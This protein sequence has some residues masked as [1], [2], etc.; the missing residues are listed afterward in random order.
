MKELKEMSVEQLE[1]ELAARKAEET[2][3]R[4]KAKQAYEV[5][6][7]RVVKRIMSQ[8]MRLN[9]YMTAF[10]TDLSTVFDEMKDEC[11]KY[12][13]IR[14]NSIGGF[15]LTNSEDN[16]RIT[17]RLDNTP[18]WDERCDKGVSLI[19]EFLVD[20][21]RAKDKKMFDILMTF[22]QRNK[23]GDMNYANIMHLLKHEDKFTDERW[24]E[25]CKLLRENYTTAFKKY[26]YVLSTKNAKGEW[27]PINLNLAA[28]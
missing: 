9:S 22:L 4:A 26:Y 18:V 21:I 23:K 14:K 17:R 11:D 13:S 19:K 7:D 8:A 5:K 6:R 16:F 25:G 2:A 28:I 3:Q 1:R 24:V 15:S 20:N 27:E 10:K 12:G